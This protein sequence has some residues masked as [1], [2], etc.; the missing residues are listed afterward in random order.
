MF[1]IRTWWLR[2]CFFFAKKKINSTVVCRCVCVC[3]HHKS[4]SCFCMCLLLHKTGLCTVATCMYTSLM[5]MDGWSS[6][7]VASSIVACTG[8]GIWWLQWIC[9]ANFQI[10]IQSCHSFSFIRNDSILFCRWCKFWCGIL[11]DL[12]LFPI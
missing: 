10:T 2:V 4:L 5:C 3:I 6:F 8:G 11:V 7:V 1:A 12:G 9:V